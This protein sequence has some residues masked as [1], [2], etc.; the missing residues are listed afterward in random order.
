MR[1]WVNISIWEWPICLTKLILTLINLNMWHTKFMSMNLVG[2]IL[3]NDFRS[4][5]LFVRFNWYLVYH[6]CNKWTESSKPRNSNRRLIFTAQ[7]NK[8]ET[9]KY[10]LGF[11]KWV[12]NS[13]LLEILTTLMTYHHYLF[14]LG[15]T[16]WYIIGTI[17]ITLLLLAIVVMVIY[18]KRIKKSRGNF[19]YDSIDT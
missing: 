7:S 4:Q 3:R 11:C 1:P 6:D 14:F 10:I 5:L 12:L 9:K 17:G 15:Y 8:S 16:K 19:K 2:F 18:G 13:S